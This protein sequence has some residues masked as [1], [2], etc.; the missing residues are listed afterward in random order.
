MYGTAR[1]DKIRNGYITGSFGTTGKCGRIDSGGLGMLKEE[2]M[3]R[4][5]SGNGQAKKEMDKGY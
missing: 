3:T 2:L 4:G 5:I 1:F